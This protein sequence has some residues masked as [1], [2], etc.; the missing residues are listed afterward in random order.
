MVMKRNEYPRPDIIRNTWWPLNGAWNFAFDDDNV[1]HQK[2]WHKHPDFPLKIEVPFAFQ[3]KLSGINDTS[4]HDNVWYHRQFSVKPYDSHK[5]YL[6]HFQAVDYQCR[7]YVDGEWIGE[8]IG[9]Q[10]PFSFEIT[11]FIKDE[12][13][14]Q[15]VV[16]VNDPSTDLF[17]PRG[18]QYWKEQSESI[19]YT[20]TTGI[21]QSVWIEEVALEYIKLIRMTPHLD[22][23]R[24]QMEVA[25]S[26]AGKTLGI[27]I[28]DHGIL[29]SKTD[30]RVSSNHLSVLLPVVTADE[31]YKKAWS[32]EN[33]YLFD[34]KLTYGSDEVT[35]YFG[36]R[37]VE[38]KNGR[39][40]L[41]NEPYYPKMVL[42]QGYWPDGLLT[43]PSVEDLRKDI[44]LSKAMGFNGA[45]K[46]QKCEDPYFAYYADKIGYLVWGEMASAV[47]FSS[48]SAWRDL[49]EWAQILPRDYNHPS[50]IAWVPLNESWGVPEIRTDQEQ[51]RHAIALYDFIRSNDRTR[52]IIGNDGWEM[53][54]TDICAVHHYRHGKKDELEKQLQFKKELATKTDVLASRPADRPLYAEG[55]AYQGEPILL[56]EFGGIS[57]VVA[58]DGWG[59]TSVRS[60]HELLDEYRRLIHD[61]K[62]S[63]VLAGYCYTQLTDVEYEV[64]GLLTYDRKPKVPVE[65]IKAIN[66]LISRK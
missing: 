59:Y 57:Y 1:G 56:T 20:R 32:P 66:D 25:V 24:I 60:G 10:A 50:I 22:S 7:V 35:T 55:Y 45:R 3:T 31:I 40:Y 28:Q 27:E 6:L 43:P 47:M 44:Q 58:N 12:G 63:Q 5:R 19:W 34:V 33:P 65:E 16:Y 11:S 9:G 39:I 64:N 8:H 53:V 2:E 37:K 14:H 38:A 61:I 30:H 48:L 49:N 4:F 54:K 41:N 13:E 26:D 23:G 42:D 51:Q 15:L 52:L 21:Y 18:K 36:M 29:I 46:H 62:D 17:L